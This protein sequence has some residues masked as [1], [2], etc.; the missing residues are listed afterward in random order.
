MSEC[1]MYSDMNILGIL[2]YSDMNSEHDQ[3]HEL[4]LTYIYN[5]NLIVM[6][7]IWYQTNIL[8]MKILRSTTT[9]PH[10]K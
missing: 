9:L 6:N 4:I 2:M 7:Y 5:I 10:I 3:D 1:N 8:L